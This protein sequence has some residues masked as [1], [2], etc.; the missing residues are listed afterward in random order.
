[1]ALDQIGYVMQTS[2]EEVKIRVMRESACGGN[3]GACHGCPSGAIIISYPNDPKHPFVIGEAVTITMQT[4][5][6]LAGTLRSYGMLTICMIVG[7]ILGYWLS[8]TEIISILGSFF[9]FILG[10]FFMQRIS[11][12]HKETIRVKRQNEGQK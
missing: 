9:G 12:K 6:F 3:C 10:T 11:K 5:E 7:A 8:K 2:E 1:M 4:R